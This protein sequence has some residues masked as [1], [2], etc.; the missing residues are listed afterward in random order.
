MKKIYNTPVMLCVE[1][2]PVNMM[3]TSE[4]TKSDVSGIS[5]GQNNDEIDVKGIS[6]KSLWEN[7]W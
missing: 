6:D 5:R 1:L 3:A 4:Y 2:R 7:E